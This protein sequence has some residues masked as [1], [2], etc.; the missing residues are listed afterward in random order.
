[1]LKVILQQ[2]AVQLNSASATSLTS[3][4]ENS[5][6][7]QETLSV[8]QRQPGSSQLHLPSAIP[9]SSVVQQKILPGCTACYYAGPTRVHWELPPAS[10]QH[11]RGVQPG[12]TQPYGSSPFWH[13]CIW[14][15]AYKACGL[16]APHSI[17]GNI[18]SWSMRQL[19]GAGAC[20]EILQCQK[21][22][23]EGRHLCGHTS[24][25]GLNPQLLV[26]APAFLS[27][28]SFEFNCGTITGAS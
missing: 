20:F 2:Q 10:L 3:I 14:G 18:L 5:L 17:Q 7:L 23:L 4:W 13:F 11:R 12:T 27:S 15:R 16:Q 6:L 21:V 8:S 25:T 1:M 22:A 24:G 26:Q 19:A 9:H 28:V